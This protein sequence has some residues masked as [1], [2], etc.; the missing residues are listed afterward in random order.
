MNKCTPTC[1]V[2]S[3]QGSY[4]N[5][6]PCAFVVHTCPVYT[7]IILSLNMSTVRVLQEEEEEEVLA[8]ILFQTSVI[9]IIY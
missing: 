8:I 3:S 7:F 2:L 6:G 5:S 1:N 9:F 4:Y